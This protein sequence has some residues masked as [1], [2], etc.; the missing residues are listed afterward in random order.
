MIIN[1]YLEGISLL[2][3]EEET[4]M[5]DT[6]LLSHPQ[7]DAGFLGIRETETAKSPEIILERAT[8]LTGL[9]IRLFNF[10]EYE[11]YAFHRDLGHIAATQQRYAIPIESNPQLI[12]GLYNVGVSIGEVPRDTVFSY[13]PRNYVYAPRSFTTYGFESTFIE[14]FRQGMGGLY[15][16][17]NHLL[18]AMAGKVTLSAGIQAATLE[19]KNMTSAIV[20]VHRQITPEQ[21]THVLRPYFDPIEIEGTSYLAP[22]GAQMPLILLDLIMKGSKY[23]DKMQS[24]SLENVSYMPLGY[25]F[26][27]E[28]LLEKQICLTNYF[29]ANEDLEAFVGLQNAV[30]GFRYP[31]RKVAT[32]NFKLREKE[33]VGSGGYTPELLDELIKL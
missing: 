31:H 16:C 14:S 30:L 28:V 11:T 21:F 25:R 18:V 2:L 5:A 4:R 32:D 10:R 29:R 27:F 17:I 1:T 15:R 7:V 19:F 8:A 22:G 9:L 20:N 24:Y 26:A 6:S 12:E 3:H 33:N 13:G 23:F